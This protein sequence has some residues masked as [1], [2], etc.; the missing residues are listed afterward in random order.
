MESDSEPFE[1][2]RPSEYDRLAGVYDRRWRRYVESTNR[3][4]FNWLAEGEWNVFLD[5]GCG[6]GY[7]LSHVADRFPDRD[8]YGVDASRAMLAVAGNRCRGR[9]RITLV[10]AEASRLPFADGRFDRIASL[11]ALHCFPDPEAALAECRRVLHGSGS[12]LVIDWNADTIPMRTMV[13]WL[14]L[15]KRAVNWVYPSLQLREI[16]R[17][18]GFDVQRMERFRVP[19]L[20]SLTAFWCRVA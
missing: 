17:D 15:S 3:R 19:P 1:G 2:R 7:L 12:M 6:T 14:R 10:E 11:S 4:A 9:E 8:L 18:T 16:L 20:W 5:V 13:A